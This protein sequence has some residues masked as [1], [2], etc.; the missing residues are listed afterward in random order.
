MKGAAW[1]LVV[2]GLLGLGGHG[3]Y[4]LFDWAEKRDV[5][6]GRAK[7]PG[8]ELEARLSHVADEQARYWRKLKPLWLPMIG[9]GLALL[10]I[11]V[12]VR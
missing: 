8:S 10:A 6:K 7:E 5:M 11:D 2:V 3:L 9:C 12:I 4:A 1:F